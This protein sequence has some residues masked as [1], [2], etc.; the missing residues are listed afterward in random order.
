MNK[1]ITSIAIFAMVLMT[2]SVFAA[3]PT[4]FHLDNTVD[5]T[6]DWAWNNGW[7][8][9]EFQTAQ[10]NMK[11]N[12]D[13]ATQASFV[14]VGKYG[15]PW[16]LD[17][18]S[19]AF[20]NAPARFTNELNAITVN[21]PDSTP[22]VAWTKVHYKQLTGSEYSQSSLKVNGFGD[23][24]VKSSFRLENEGGQTIDLNIN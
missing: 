2:A 7:Q 14:E 17:Y 23:I 22:G 1:K 11:I 24:Y 12:S 8:Q 18:D 6:G 9:G 19:D 10:F 3:I 15:A 4:G 5:V 21:P 16:H 13:L 20:V